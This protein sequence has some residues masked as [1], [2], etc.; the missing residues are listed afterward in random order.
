MQICNVLM[1]SLIFFL[2]HPSLFSI[3]LSYC[4]GCGSRSV[5]GHRDGNCLVC[6]GQCYGPGWTIPS[7]GPWRSA[8]RILLGGG[9]G[10]DCRSAGNG[11]E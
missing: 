7:R 10:I 5:G 6:L 3:T 2:V 9:P 8:G 4:L 1:T 11:I